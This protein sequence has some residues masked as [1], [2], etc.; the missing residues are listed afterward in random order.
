MAW[1]LLALQL[2][3]AAGGLPAGSALLEKQHRPAVVLEWNWAQALG[4]RRS[5]PRHTPRA[6][7]PTPQHLIP[8]Q[9][10]KWLATPLLESEESSDTSAQE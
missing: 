8:A 9:A 10:P 1:S 2:G 7:H 3:G 6:P 4:F 5:L